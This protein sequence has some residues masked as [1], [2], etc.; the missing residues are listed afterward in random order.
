ML[1]FVIRSSNKV[2]GMRLLVIELESSTHRSS[3]VLF[4]CLSTC[5]TFVDVMALEMAATELCHRRFAPFFFDLAEPDC[6]N[7]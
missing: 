6:P 4:R 3:L 2:K 7:Q 5:G 1:L